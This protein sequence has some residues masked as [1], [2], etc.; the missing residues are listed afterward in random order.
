[1]ERCS[2]KHWTIQGYSLASS[3]NMAVE[4]AAQE[5]RRGEIRNEILNP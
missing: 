2:T 3:L 4:M 5:A 1:M